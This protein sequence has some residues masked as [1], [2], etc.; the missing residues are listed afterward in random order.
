MMSHK[1][2]IG[3]VGVAGVT[4]VAGVISAALIGIIPEFPAML[5]DTGGL[6]TY[7]ATADLFSV[8]AT[9][10]GVVPKNGV[11][12]GDQ[13]SFENNAPHSAGVGLR[14]IPRHRAIDKGRAA[15]EVVYSCAQ[16]CSIAVNR[17]IRVGRLRKLV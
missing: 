3:A 4:S 2:L 15:A 11:Y 9:P 1:H 14:R 10:I 13:L 16:R 17:A 12:D 7:D 8:E 6:T 5:Y